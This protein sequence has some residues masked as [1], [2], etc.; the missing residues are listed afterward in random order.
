[1][2]RRTSGQRRVWSIS[3]KGTEPLTA[4]QLFT[5]PL[6]ITEIMR[7]IPHR[8][9]FLLIDRILEIRDKFIVSQKCV[10][11]NEPFFA[12]HFPGRPIM[13]GVLMLE[14]MAQTGAVMEQLYPENR[15]KLIVL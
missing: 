12:G 4:S 3:A 11:V 10:T 1:M 15:G 6:D 7:I 8:Y 9:P 2:A 14:A 5:G 13:P